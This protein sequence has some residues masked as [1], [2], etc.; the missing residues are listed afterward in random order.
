MSWVGRVINRTHF[1]KNY[2]YHAT[3]A[4]LNQNI[5]DTKIKKHQRFIV[6]RFLQP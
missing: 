4:F 3:N 5:I 1:T 2:T 6:A